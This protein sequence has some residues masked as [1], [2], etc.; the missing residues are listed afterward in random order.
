MAFLDLQ[1]LRGSG[2]RWADGD[3]PSTLSILGCEFKSSL[4]LLLC[5][6]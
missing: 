3:K 1:G 6:K 2:T 4:S 5:P